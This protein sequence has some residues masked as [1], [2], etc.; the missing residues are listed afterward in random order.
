VLFFEEPATHALTYFAKASMREA[1]F[2]H[3][4]TVLEHGLLEGAVL[5]TGGFAIEDTE[6]GTITFADGAEIYIP[7]N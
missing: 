6:T 1:R 7:K 4:A 3:A 5:I 2:G